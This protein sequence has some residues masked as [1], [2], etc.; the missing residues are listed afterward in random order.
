[1]VK[2]LFALLSRL[3]PALLIGL[4]LVL[5]L[6]ADI[7]LAK[8]YYFYA[9]A[10]GMKAF[11]R[12]D[13]LNWRGPLPLAGGLNQDESLPYLL[14]LKTVHYFISDRLLCMRLVSISAGAATLIFLYLIGKSLLSRTI[15]LVALYFLV[16]NPAFLETARAYGYHSLSHMVS[17]LAILFAV[18][19]GRQRFWW[20]AVSFSAFACFL[21]L[22][23]YGWMRLVTIPWV[24]VWYL[25]SGRGWCRK[26]L[27]FCGIFGA[28]I[29]AIGVFQQGDS[30]IISQVFLTEGWNE[31]AGTRQSALDID[32][33]LGHLQHNFP[34]LLGYL[35]NLKRI[36]FAT[37]VVQSRI[38]NSAY[39]PFWIIGLVICGWRRRR[40]HIMVLLM[41][42]FFALPQLPSNSLMPHR[43]IFILYPLALLIGSGVTGVY[44]YVTR[45]AL[46]QSWNR[47]VRASF[48]AFL[49]VVGVFN[50]KYF[51]FELSR[52]QHAVSPEDLSMIADFILEQG[53]KNIRV[54]FPRDFHPYIYGNKYLV[55]R[56]T[57]DYQ[58][59]SID[60]KSLINVIYMTLIDRTPFLAVF[61]HPA[62]EGF[63]WAIDWAQERFPESTMISSLPNSEFGVFTFMPP[64]SISPNLLASEKLKVSLSDGLREKP[65]ISEAEAL[66][67]FSDGDPTTW[68]EIAPFQE[69]E[70]PRVIFDF[71]NNNKRVPRV[72]LASPAD[73]HPHPELFMRDAIISASPDGK[74]WEILSWIKG[75]DDPWLGMWYQWTFPGEQP[76]RYYQV[77][78]YEDDGRPA[79]SVVIGELGLFESERHWIG[80]VA[81]EK[82][83]RCDD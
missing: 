58:I 38:S 21:L 20:W 56:V 14:L 47:V 61:H 16:T 80:L 70:P 24:I 12:L 18:L 77:E 7:W 1:M 26:T 37:E 15:A 45:F 78:F 46:R 10:H 2:P 69:G 28:L 59:R 68:V 29:I 73:H 54:V 57:K 40:G 11:Y 39:V 8:K 49:L 66:N 83:A 6:V 22:Y 76:F 72:I 50:T 67:N 51:L 62:P 42:A 23:L 25:F 33:F 17:I 41:L 53:G 34:I 74:D 60:P 13:N 71:G 31:Y 43:V 63:A 27:L 55:N 3:L 75:D 79:Q 35:F 9:E 36:E 5:A 44:S 32:R 30:S 4:F 64:P 52:P 19:S 65:V 82:M 48:C 81:H